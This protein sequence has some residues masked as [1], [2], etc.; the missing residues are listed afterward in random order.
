MAGYKIETHSMMPPR[1]IRCPN[2]NTRHYQ[3]RTETKR[4]FEDG[5]Y[6]VYCTCGCK[7]EV[8]NKVRMSII[9]RDA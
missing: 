4:Y 2:C 5:F 7:Y 8:I 9:R 6:S 1:S 3:L